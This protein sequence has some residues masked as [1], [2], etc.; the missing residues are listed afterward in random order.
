MQ[1][2]WLAMEYYRLDC[3]ESWKDGPRKQATREAI[4][5]TIASLSGQVSTET[6]TNLPCARPPQGR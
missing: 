3:L 2:Q 5:S 1:N 4:L 6:K